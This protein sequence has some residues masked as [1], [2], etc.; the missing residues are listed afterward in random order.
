MNTVA[1]AVLLILLVM[2]SSSVAKQVLTDPEVVHPD[3]QAII[4]NLEAIT[5]RDSNSATA[6]VAILLSSSNVKCDSGSEV[7]GALSGNAEGSL[8]MLARK[9]DGTS[10]GVNGNTLRISASFTPIGEI[11]ANDIVSSIMQKKPLLIRWK[12]VVYVAYGVVY[13][14]HLFNSGRQDNVI[15]EFLL[16]DPRFSDSRRLVTFRRQKDDFGQIEGIMSTSLRPTQ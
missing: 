1:N 8:S 9:I 10:C 16:I 11:R 7:E 5:L 13:D 12:E 15:R 14:Q 3:Q 2:S 6:A 4:P